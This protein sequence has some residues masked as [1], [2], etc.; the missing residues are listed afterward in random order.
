MLEV[1]N[2]PE[3]AKIFSGLDLEELYIAS[4]TSPTFIAVEPFPSV[5][6]SRNF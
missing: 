6:G 5:T 1:T 4:W 3:R 2:L